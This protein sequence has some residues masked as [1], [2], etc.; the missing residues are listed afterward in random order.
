[1]D[2]TKFSSQ[3]VK[4]KALYYENSHATILIVKYL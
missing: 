1:M 2:K 4:V 3:A